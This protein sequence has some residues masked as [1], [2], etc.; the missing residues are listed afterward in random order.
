MFDVDKRL[1]LRV[2]VNRT[3]ENRTEE[4]GLVLA[5]PVHLEPF[6]LYSSTIRSL[7]DLAGGGE[8][9]VPS[10]PVGTARAL[11]LL[12]D[13]GLLRLRVGSGMATSVRDVTANPHLVRISGATPQRMVHGHKTALASIMSV[14]TARSVGLRP[15]RDALALETAASNPHADG[16][17]VRAGEEDAARIATL[18]E[19]L[20]SPRVG[21]YIE[22]T[23]D[24]SVLP[25]P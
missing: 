10:D 14:A 12:A 7:S 19:V 23:Y 11:R 13:H 5:A 17:V 1:G 15:G 16:L 6:A 2:G 22:E 18:A 24:H 3:E 25:V 4:K 8:I 9:F 20:R 21:A